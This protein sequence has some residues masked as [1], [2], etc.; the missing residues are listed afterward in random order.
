MLTKKMMIMMMMIVFLS[1][2]HLVCW[3]RVAVSL[4]CFRM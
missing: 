4:S 3:Q 1:V 2:Y